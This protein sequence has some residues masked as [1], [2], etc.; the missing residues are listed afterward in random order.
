MDTKETVLV[1][2][3]DR[4]IVGAIAL[5]L[6][7]EGYR[8][9]RAYDGMEALDHALDPELRLILMDVMMPRLDGLSAVLRIRERRN[10]PIIV[11]SAKSEESDKVLGLSMGADDYVTKPFS[12]QELVARVRSQ[13]RRYTRLG[14]VNASARDQR[15]VNGRLSYDPD[16][17]V[18]TADGDEV[19]LTATELGILDL[20]MCNYVY[21]HV[22]DNTHHTVSYKSILP[23]DRVFAW[24]EIGRF[25]PSQN[26]LMHTVIYRTQILRD[27]G[28]ELPK[29][30][31]Y[32]DNIFVYQPLPQVKSI[33]YMNED[34]YRYFIGR[35]DQSV[36]EQ[37]M[38]KRVDQ[39]LRVT[40]IMLDFYSYDTLRSFEPKLGT[41]MLRYLSMMMMISSIFL[42]MSE[43]PEN[44]EKKD[45][46]WKDLKAKDPAMYKKLHYRA[47]SIAGTFPG[48]GGRKLSVGLYH[49]AQKIYKFN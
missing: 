5:A 1:V 48:K 34:L 33:Y 37:V 41:Y 15:I 23:Q 32:V 8:V 9:L 35:D 6:E 30:T 49:I 24:D 25:P 43:E 44:L 45:K 26:I 12:T 42:I 3:D 47:L 18:L 31:F 40:R 21:E 39:Q 19:K 4:E 20:L 46:L 29:H 13:L 22:V 16:S 14:D 7:K 28:L 17:R 2:D 10:L 38:I 27:S 36:N 11:L